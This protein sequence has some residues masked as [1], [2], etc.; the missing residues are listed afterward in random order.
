M[1]TRHILTVSLAVVASLWTGSVCRCFAN[2]TQSSLVTKDVVTTAPRKYSGVAFSLLFA[3][4]TSNIDAILVPQLGATSETSWKLGHWSGSGGYRSAGSDFRVLGRGIGYWIT[5]QDTKTITETGTQPSDQYFVTQ[6]PGAGEWYQMGNPYDQPLGLGYI[7]VN[8]TSAGIWTLNNP[9]NPLT[10]QSV[11]V[12]DSSIQN[13]AVVGSTGTVPPFGMYWVRTNPGVETPIFFVV[14]NPSNPPPPYAGS[15]L[16]PQEAGTLTKSSERRL[17]SLTLTAREGE[18]RSVPVEIGARSN[19]RPPSFELALPPDPPGAHVRLGAVEPSS[20]LEYGSA[21]QPQATIMTWD[22]QLNSAEAP[23]QVWLEVK[24]DVP[25]GRLLFLNDVER[26][27]EWEITPG[28]ELALT[29][30]ERPRRI[31][32]RAEEAG[33]SMVRHRASFRAYPTPSK[34]E[35]ALVSSSMESGSFEATIYDVRGRRVRSM[36]P[37]RQSQGESVLLWDG[38]DDR[39]RAVAN[40]VYLARCQSGRDAEI[41]RLIVLR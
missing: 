6:L 32:L 13:Y 40:G 21:Y 27:A 25:K 38:H 35:I 10:Q 33:T 12:W 20:K 41:L 9:L 18:E 29:A 39:G 8:P 2:A 37:V 11:W 15:A 1:L 17:W 4:D 28:K 5:T 7:T 26:G 24:G 36:A 31:R 22:F 14:W 34:G 30:T 23:G 16:K 19:D 3:P